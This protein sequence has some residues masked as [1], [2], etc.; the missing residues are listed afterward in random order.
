MI[1]N[2]IYSRKTDTKPLDASI[3]KKTNADVKKAYL[4]TLLNKIAKLIVNEM[5]KEVMHKEEFCGLSSDEKPNHQAHKLSF[6]QVIQFIN[7][8]AYFRQPMKTR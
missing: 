1:Q 8:A 2:L 7:R 5:H 6:A 4:K 3:V